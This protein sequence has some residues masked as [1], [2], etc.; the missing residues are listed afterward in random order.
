MYI[1]ELREYIL[2]MLCLQWSPY[3]ADLKEKINGHLRDQKKLMAKVRLTTANCNINDHFSLEN[4][5]FQGCFLHFFCIYNRKL[6][7][8][9]AI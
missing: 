7:K 1:A 2:Y 6:R 9:L 8:K 4:H 5:T 3:P